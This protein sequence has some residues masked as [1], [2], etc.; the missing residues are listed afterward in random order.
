MYDKIIS[1]KE[2]ADIVALNKASGIK[3]VNVHGCFDILHFGHILYFETAK[4][5]GEKLLVSV[6]P[7][8]YVFKGPNRP[9]M[10]EMARLKYI[11]S[12]EIVD[13]VVLNDQEDALSFLQNVQPDLTARGIE[14]KELEKD[15]TGKISLELEVVKSYGG[16]LIFIDEETYSST[17]IINQ[18]ANNLT[19]IQ[20]KYKEQIIHFF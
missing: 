15:V 9:F 7:D 17:K 16:E 2:A 12:L 11:A 20:R 19:D 8:Q 13:Y 3:T 1:L 10:N 18:L 6:T 4:K 14:Y 5:H